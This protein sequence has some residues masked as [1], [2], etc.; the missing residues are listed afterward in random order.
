MVLLFCL[1][2]LLAAASTADAAEPSAY[3]VLT[4]D[5]VW[6]GVSQSDSDPAVQLGG[7][8]AFD[9]GVFVGIWGSTIDI[10]NGPAIQR[11]TEV[12]YYLGYSY[13]T[14]GPWTLGAS[15]VAYTYPGQ[16]GF[17]DYNYEELILSVNFDD[18]AWFAYAYSPDLY[19]SDEASHNFELFTELPAGEHLLVG[20]GIGYYD[21]SNLVDVGYAYWEL[22]VTYPIDR[23]DFDLRY[24]DTSGWVPI[25]STPD[26]ADARIVLSIRMSF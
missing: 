19:H 23:F 13:D 1:S 6:R 22:G 20:A 17:I 21:I 12:I 5:Y 18:R 9:S 2:G 7:E 26:R 16:T 14:G 3:V 25:V 8:V 10:S 4:T 11:D 15:I 24:H